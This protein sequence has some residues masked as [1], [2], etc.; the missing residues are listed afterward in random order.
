MGLIWLSEESGMECWGTLNPKRCCFC[1]FAR[2]VAGFRYRLQGLGCVH[3]DSRDHSLLQYG[4]TVHQIFE[5]WRKL[6]QVIRSIEDVAINHETKRECTLMAV[7][8][9]STSRRRTPP[10]S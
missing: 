8:S 1:S 5:I 7:R 6:V 3:G 4:G 9:S 10:N 2:G